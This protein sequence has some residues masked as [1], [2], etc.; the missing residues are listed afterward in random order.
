MATE[1]H[2][3]DGSAW[4][5]AKE[6]HVHDGSAWRKLK[7]MWMHDGTNWRK[8]FKST[9]AWEQLLDF[10][11][12]NGINWRHF[13][14]PDRDE[15]WVNISDG[16]LQ[17][18]CASLTVTK[19]TP[20]F[21]S[22]GSS[23]IAGIGSDIY[24]I[25]A[26]SATTGSLYRFSGGTWT[27]LGE[28]SGRSLRQTLYANGS[29]L[30]A[31]GTLIASPFTRKVFKYD[32]A[33]TDLGTPTFGPGE[34]LAYLAHSGGANGFIA[35]VGGGSPEGVFGLIAGSWVS[36]SLG[37]IDLVAHG[38]AVSRDSSEHWFALADGSAAKK[39]TSDGTTLSVSTISLTS[40]V[41][42]PF[43]TVALG[44]SLPHMRARSGAANEIYR[45]HGADQSP[46]VDGSGVQVLY[47]FTR[48][49][50][51]WATN[52]ATLARLA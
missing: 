45:I 18:D 40:P 49:G 22:G 13:Y 12:Y 39:L 35:A 42:S 7:E 21:S 32:G 31:I 17:I 44:D 33:W 2:I 3:H 14:S 43:T 34:H 15:L 9:L 51:L 8:V 10:T 50:V 25:A 28:P 41:S 36:A 19:H 6:L 1:T 20:F 23:S 27:N 52:G 37:T 47:G 24:C 30:Y 26:S 5:K 11:S 38:W 16:V 46:V 48:D 4:R 29:D